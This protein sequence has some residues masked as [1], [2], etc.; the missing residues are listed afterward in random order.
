MATFVSNRDS[1]GRT[2]EEGHLRF[3]AASFTGNVLSGQQVTENSPN[4][5]TVLV[6]EGQI[7]IPYSDYAYMAWSEGNTIVSVATADPSNP[8]IDRVVAYID[9]SMSF[10]DTDINNPGMLKYKAV[11]GTPNAVPSAPND[12]AVNSSVSNNPW[13]ELARISV[14]AA[15][16]SVTN[17][18]ITDTRSFV[19]LS[20]NVQ[21]AHLMPIGTMLDYAGTTAPSGFLL[22]YGQTISRTTYKDLFG[23]IGTIYGSGDGSTTFNLPDCRGRVSAGKDNMGGTSANRLTNP[24]SS[25]TGGIDGDGLANT[26]GSETH[27]I[28]E[29]QLPALTGNHAAMVPSAHGSYRSG[30]VSAGGQNYGSASYPA[31]AGTNSTTTWSWTISFGGNTPH[32]N[33]QPTIIFNKIIKT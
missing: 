8:R 30:I 22:C 10:V 20:T 1:G 33:V 4:A 16:S 32:N 9:R 23:I 6:S 3:L 21:A 26:G 14:T 5:M 28:T 12:A 24:T 19:Q 11:T 18:K 17:A 27:S 7:R 15:L 25:T 29:P 2:D 31:A 13:V